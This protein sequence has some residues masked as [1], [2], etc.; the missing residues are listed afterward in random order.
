MSNSMPNSSLVSQ[1]NQIFSN[2]SLKP[3]ANVQLEN[4]PKESFQK[5]YKNEIS[6]GVKKPADTNKPLPKNTPAQ[7]NTDKSIKA[8]K[9][10]ETQTNNKT[11]ASEEDDTEISD[12]LAL[13]DT[14]TL[15]DLVDHI[16]AITNQ[17]TANRDFEHQASKEST[18]TVSLVDTSIAT[19]IQTTGP[20]PIQDTLDAGQVIDI[21]PS[22]EGEQVKEEATTTNLSAA[23]SEE[24]AI[25]EISTPQAA[26]SQKKLEE[27]Y[28]GTQIQSA[29][30]AALTKKED[31]PAPLPVAL[32][33]PEKNSQL[34]QVKLTVPSDAPAPKTVSS[35]DKASLAQA[36]DLVQGRDPMQAHKST[37][38]S[39]E[40]NTKSELFNR[41][42]ASRFSESKA[43]QLEPIQS[44]TTVAASP[45]LPALPPAPGAAINAIAATQMQDLISLRVGSKGWDQ[46]LGQKMIWM[47]AGEE[48]SVQLS[49][50]PPDLG[51]LQIVLSVNDNQ[52]DASFISEHLDVREAIEA[53]SPKLKEMMDN[54]GISLSG[55]SVSAQAHSSDNAFAQAQQQR[56]TS[57]AS[58]AAKREASNAEALALNQN[59]SSNLGGKGLVDTFV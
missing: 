3:N 59:R 20:A 5:V 21:K 42:L 53:A 40:L 41:E 8:Q 51:P 9:T 55:F 27:R 26:P 57:N 29:R 58:Q 43:S 48:S 36:S 23:L 44:T 38:N 6:N 24:K 13:S 47:V 10:D 34:N 11:T 16:V 14:S 18:L 54:A 7:A 2:N 37:Q 49:L 45:L 25:Q 12:P 17:S 30:Q 39:L 22:S 15:L 33:T 4:K 28:T 52:I 56:S 35:S 19:P 1:I 46:A 32:P 31:A 50:N